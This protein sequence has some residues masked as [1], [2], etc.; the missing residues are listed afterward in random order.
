MNTIKIEVIW[1]DGT[2]EDG[3][4][5]ITPRFTLEVEDQTLFAAQCYFN[6]YRDTLETEDNGTSI[7][8]VTYMRLCTDNADQWFDFFEHPEIELLDVN[9]HGWKLEQ[10]KHEREVRYTMKTGL[11]NS[12]LFELPFV[13]TMD[14]S[15]VFARVC[16]AR[17]EEYLDDNWFDDQIELQLI[18]T[19]DQIAMAIMW[20][21]MH[22]TAH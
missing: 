22:D 6:G 5:N 10:T 11:W 12:T 15:G 4:M 3:D 14:N 16:D 2:E 7:G 17:T 20:I 21:D 1:A 18:G 13:E 19:V 9:N 8:N